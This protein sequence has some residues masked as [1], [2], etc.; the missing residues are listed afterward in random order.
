MRQDP[1]HESNPVI[2]E[3]YGNL[4]TVT[5]CAASSI[6]K[7]VPRADAGSEAKGRQVSC[8]CHSAWLLPLAP[9]A[10]Q[11]WHRYVEGVHRI[12]HPEFPVTSGATQKRFSCAFLLCT[13]WDASAETDALQG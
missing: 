4:S 5:F 2:S 3:R 6:A 7:R 10:R 1:A 11:C 9:A 8:S 13:S 12:D